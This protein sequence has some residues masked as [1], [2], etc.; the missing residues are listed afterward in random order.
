MEIRPALTPEMVKDLKVLVDYKELEKNLRIAAA[1]FASEI[2]ENY[3]LEPTQLAK[4]LL[5]QS[6]SPRLNEMLLRLC[7]TL[8][9]KLPP[10][11]IEG[12]P[13]LNI[14]VLQ[15]LALTTYATHEYA[16]IRRMVI[17]EKKEYQDSTA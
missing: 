16:R 12:R 2:S 11:I 8:F 7:D 1:E 17:F 4:R 9:I 3:T 15:L 13:I 10:S 14:D 6:E 5:D